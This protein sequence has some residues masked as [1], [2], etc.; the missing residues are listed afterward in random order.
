[1]STHLA[2]ISKSPAQQ[3]LD[4]LQQLPTHELASQTEKRFKSR[5]DKEKRNPVSFSE[6]PLLMSMVQ[7]HIA[8]IETVFEQ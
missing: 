2:P 1:M 6:D 4:G 5:P 8:R 3:G 7:I